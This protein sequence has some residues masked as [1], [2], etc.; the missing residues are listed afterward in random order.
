LILSK[1]NYKWRDAEGLILSKGELQERGWQRIAI[2]EGNFKGWDDEGSLSLKGTTSSDMMMKW[3]LFLKG[4]SN[5]RMLKDW[6]Y[7]RELQVTGWWRIF[8]CQRELQMMGWWRNFIVK[9]NF[10]WR[11]DEGLLLAKWTSSDWMKKDS[12]E[13]IIKDYVFSI[14]TNFCPWREYCPQ[15]GAISSPL[16]HPTWVQTMSV[17]IVFGIDWN[18]KGNPLVLC[19]TM[20]NP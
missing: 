3:F 17:W 8:Y 7:G 10:K 15:G 20:Q 2:V 6:Y 18:L 9:G 11:D 12:Y 1:G 14:H 19:D 16:S 4:T 13:R 5:D